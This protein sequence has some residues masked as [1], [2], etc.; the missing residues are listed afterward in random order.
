MVGIVVVSHSKKLAD[1]VVELALQMGNPEIKLSA[2]GGVDDPENPI[3]T[4]AMKIL[5]SIKEVYHDDGVILMMDMGSAIL[6]AATAVDF[7]DDSMKDNVKLCEAP[8]VEGTISAVVQAA[9]GGNIEQVLEEARKSLHP[10]S[11]QLGIETPDEHDADQED[12]SIQNGEV[13]RRVYTIRNQIGIHARP[14]AKIVTL[15][16]KFDAGVRIRNYT[17]DSAYVKARSINNLITLNVRKDDKIVVET[18]GL[19]S[20]AA[21]EAISELIADNFGE[22]QHHH[23]KPSEKKSRVKKVSGAVEGIA[24][25]AGIAIGPAYRHEISMPEVEP[26]TIDDPKTELARFERAVEKAKRELSAVFEES[27]DTVGTYEASIFEAHA[28][29][30]DD[31]EIMARVQKNI[32]EKHLSAEYAW[33]DSV[34]SVL[35]KYEESQNDAVKSR[36]IDLID[37]GLRVYHLLSGVKAIKIRLPEPGIL[38]STELSPSDTATLD[39]ENVLGI[40]CESGSDVSHSAIIARTLGIPAVFGVGELINEVQDGQVAALNG[41]AGHFYPSPDEDQLK[42]LKEIRKKWLFEKQKAYEARKN[43]AETKDGIRISALANVASVND[44]R[45]AIEAGA[46]GV[47]L[48]RTEYLFMDRDGPPDEEEQFEVYKEAAGILDGKPL[49]IRTLDVG[50]DKPIPYLGIEKEEN[51]FL[52]WRGIRY[53]L[54]EREIFITQV[55]AILRASRFGNVSMMFPMV[56]TLDEIREAKALTREVMKDL[57]NE[58][59]AFNAAIKTGIM[60]EVPAAVTSA[61]E[62]AKHAGFFSIGTNDLTQYIMAADRTNGKVSG[63]AS[64]FQPA[65]IN[66]IKKTIE[67]AQ[68]AGIEVAM[69]GEMARNTKATPLLLSLGLKEFSMSPVGIPEFKWKLS[70]LSLKECQ[71]KADLYLKET[72]IEGVKKMLG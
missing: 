4:D 9:A 19:D 50:G 34:N 22:N 33:V 55:R 64:P 54:E 32:S 53:G 40:C 67:A 68:K 17:N 43:K 41:E 58:G 59:I 61:D 42:Q 20:A 57:E 26:G 18:S 45:E 5:E 1:G 28:L 39:K 62:L 56:G 12:A 48:F 51:P 7:L 2:A 31:P 24:V 6:S 71:K 11:A 23:K 52:G 13:Y 21:Q 46:D 47:G 16:G 10:K 15:T 66:A 63:L 44:I 8:L 60:I 25:S 72:D 27:S 36:A 37:V 65:V 38:I 30:I 69:C 3:G 29:F 70:E 14:A 49:V 35:K